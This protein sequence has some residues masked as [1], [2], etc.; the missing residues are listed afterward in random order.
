MSK[1]PSA[2]EIINEAIKKDPQADLNRLH[3]LTYK[4]MIS[5]RDAYYQ[6]RVNNFLKQSSL[7]SLSNG[8]KQLV[9]KELLRPIM[10]ENKSYSNFMEE[11]SRRISQTF[12]PISGNLAEL[13][14]EKELIDIGLKHKVHYLRKKGHTDLEIYHPQ[15]ENNL[16]TH[17]V[18]VKNVA[19]RERGVRG[20][21][22]DGDSIIGFFSDPSEFTEGNIDIIDQH[23]HK[24]GGYCYLPPCTLSSLGQKVANKRF[25]SNKDFAS[26]IKRFVKT[27]SI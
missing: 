2:K 25:K 18:E 5:Y 22:F 16:N 11:V 27:G 8:T 14:V 15:L 23:C 1:F 17:R 20:L 3:S 7:Q 24:V 6:S 12:Q 9:K 4:F 21:K 10:V 26:D 19:L 13:C